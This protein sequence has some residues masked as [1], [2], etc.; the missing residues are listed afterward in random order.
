MRDTAMAPGK[1]RPLD[2]LRCAR[3]R[4]FRCRKATA[5]SLDKIIL[6]RGSPEGE[7]GEE[8]QDHNW[9][10]ISPCLGQ[11]IVHRSISIEK[12][13]DMRRPDVDRQKAG[14]V[15]AKVVD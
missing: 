6:M 5:S 14:V 10:N 11:R 7:L 2:R 12:R 13:R 3:M 15:R 1:Q 9:H 8:D 4:G